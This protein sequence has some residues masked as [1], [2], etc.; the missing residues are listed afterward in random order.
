MVEK[1]TAR[2]AKRVISPHEPQ[3]T[4]DADPVDN[5]AVTS[6][7]SVPKV[8][9]R[10]PV[11]IDRTARRRAVAQRTCLCPPHLPGNRDPVAV[12]NSLGDV[13]MK[14]AEWRSRDREPLLERLA[15][16]R[17]AV[18]W[19][20]RIAVDDVVV[21]Q[22]RVDRRR[23]AFIPNLLHESV[24][25]LSIVGHRRGINSGYWSPRQ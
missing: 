1:P 21:G 12:R 22:E 25:R 20:A 4:R 18:P 3:L 17:L 5:L 16:K 7:S 9:N 11:Y 15:R 6:D 19:I 10:H 14:I 8:V 2:N 13:E 24:E 23:V